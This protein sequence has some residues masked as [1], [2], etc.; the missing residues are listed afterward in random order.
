MDKTHIGTLCAPDESGVSVF[1]PSEGLPLC[2]IPAD[3]VLEDLLAR[4]PFPEVSRIEIK[5]TNIMTEQNENQDAAITG[6]S[7]TEAYKKAMLALI[8]NPEEVVAGVV[9]GFY[10]TD[11]EDANPRRGFQIMLTASRGART[12]KEEKS[13]IIV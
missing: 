3:R 10:W 5:Q 7:L 11:P 12:K 1:L 9:A 6:E 2:G 13:S 8:Q 4:S